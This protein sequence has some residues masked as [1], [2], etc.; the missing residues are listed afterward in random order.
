MLRRRALE[1]AGPL[2]AGGRVKGSH[3]SA[4]YG[5]ADDHR[6]APSVTSEFMEEAD[7]AGKDGPM[8][9]LRR[10]CPSDSS[11]PLSAEDI[12][13]YL[14]RDIW[15]GLEPGTDSLRFAISGHGR[16]I[17]EFDPADRP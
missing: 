9:L 13:V 1:E 12:Q 11:A 14:A 6:A 16:F 5:Q 4:R 3:R 7:N 10:G 8:W 17:L 15:E 2:G